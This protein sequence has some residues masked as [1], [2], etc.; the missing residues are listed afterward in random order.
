MVED[1]AVTEGT[2]SSAF[3]VDK[4]GVLRTQPLGP[5]ILPGV[6]RRAI[7]R[8]AEDDGIAFEERPFSVEEAYEAREALMT[9]ASAFVLPVISIDGRDIGA[10][11][12]GPIARAFRA[13]YIAEARAA[14]A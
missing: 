6:T 13:H 8:L 9:A 10:G 1:G 12:P 14:S 11:E 4:Q 3:I 7:L 5:Q 2:S